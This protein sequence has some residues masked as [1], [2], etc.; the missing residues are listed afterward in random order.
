LLKDI[1]PPR[2]VPHGNCP[3]FP[4]EAAAPVTEWSPIHHIF[5]LE[6]ELYFQRSRLSVLGFQY[7][8]TRTN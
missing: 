8:I 6:S 7:R 2:T 1:D 4:P 5:F 3:A